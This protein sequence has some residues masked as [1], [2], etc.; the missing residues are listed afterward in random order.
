MPNL[1]KR[2][3]FRAPAPA[4]ALAALLALGACQSRASKGDP[5][6]DARPFPALPAQNVDGSIALEARYYLDHKRT[7]GVE[8]PREARVLPIAVKVGLAPGAAASVRFD[9]REAAP[10]LYLPDGTVVACKPVEAIHTSYRQVNDTLVKKALGASVLAP[11]SAAREANL[12]FELGAAG[13]LFVK[14]GEVSVRQ[15]ELSQ[16]FGLDEALL[17]FDLE[18]EGRKRTVYVGIALANG[19]KGR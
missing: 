14:R 15:G 19:A 2:R 8:L 17:A 6:L 18:L 9:P 1:E 7:F 3:R 16:T 11:W 13:E 5:G 4:F 12:Y 10:R